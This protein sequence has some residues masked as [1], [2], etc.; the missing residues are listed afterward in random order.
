MSLLFVSLFASLELHSFAL[1]H[2]LESKQM[3][4]P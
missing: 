3:D 2:I 1:V 4:R